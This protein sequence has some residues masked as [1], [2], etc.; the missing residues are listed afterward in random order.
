[1]IPQ[2]KQYWHFNVFN[3]RMSVENILVA[4]R[5][6]Q[7]KKWYTRSPKKSGILDLLKKGEQIFT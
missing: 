6:K 5:C 1:M 2:K 3:S 7:E 4:P